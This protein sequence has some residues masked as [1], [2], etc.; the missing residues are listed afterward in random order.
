MADR[1]GRS[2]ERPVKRSEEC[3]KLFLIS[4]RA[5]STRPPKAEIPIR[6]RH[7]CLA[8]GQHRPFGVC[9]DGKGWLRGH[10]TNIICS[11]GG[12]QPDPSVAVTRERAEP[13]G[14]VTVLLNDIRP[15]PSS[16][17][18]VTPSP[19]CVSRGCACPE[20][21]GLCCFGMSAE[22][23]RSRGL[24][25][26]QMGTTARLPKPL[27]TRAQQSHGKRIVFDTELTIT[28]QSACS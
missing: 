11:S 23:D 28:D 6:R 27:R 20:G 9:R 15:R 25:R 10:A 8:S 3:L 26:V 1:A 22:V 5:P 16:I 2:P 19:P 14:N 12:P 7:G 4:V 13:P 21:H 24:A 17:F 18:L